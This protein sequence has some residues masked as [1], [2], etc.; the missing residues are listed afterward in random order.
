MAGFGIYRKGRSFAHRLDPR[1]KVT[2]AAVF[3]VVGFLA[4]GWAALALVAAAAV[5]MACAAGERPSQAA[6]ALRPFAPLMVFIGVFDALFVSSGTVW[7]Q[8][9]PLALSAG[10]CS[11][12]ADSLVR[13]A[14]VLLATSLLMRVAS[15][16]ELSDAVGLMLAPRARGGTAADQAA[17]AVGMTL[18][19][20]S[21]I[22]QELE[23]VKS[24]Q[25]LRGARFDTG[26]V[27]ARLKAYHPV[28]VPLFIGTFHRADTLAYAVANRGF[29]ATE[30]PR[31]S[32]RA[33]AFG[34]RD[35]ATF[36]LLLL[37]VA[38]VVAAGIMFG[39]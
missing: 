6:R 37:F 13:F 34:R 29:G 12:A 23:R 5:L 24:M 33:Y 38:L 31:T 1:T 15:P 39:G 21:V 19:F 35:A 3:I 36:I 4:R 9:G 27:R 14:A 7:W 25:M 30:R 32:Y 20:V 2:A 16:T 22:S 26:G 17:L 28:L 18:R 10:G 11:L 8:A